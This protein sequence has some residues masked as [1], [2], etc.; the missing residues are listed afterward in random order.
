MGRAFDETLAEAGGSLPMWL[1]LLNLKINPRA[2]QRE[3]AEAVGLREATITHHLNAMEN[4]GLL[5]RR[6]DPGNRRIHIIEI[7]DVGNILFLRLRDAAV[8]FD[9]RL[10]HG[11]DQPDLEKLSE[12]LDRLADNVGGNTRGPPRAGLEAAATSGQAATDAVADPL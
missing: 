7:N 9:R 12:V 8:S 10:R 3:L 11:I 4:D 5:T 2:T 1:V 6:R